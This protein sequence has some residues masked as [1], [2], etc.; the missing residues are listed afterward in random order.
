MNAP[1][2]EQLLDI[3]RDVGRQLLAARLTIATAESCTG[4]L[5]AST[6]T[7]VA[8]SSEYV[9]G[10]VVCYRNSVKEDMLRVHHGTLEL[11]GAVSPETAAEM[12]RGVRRLFGCDVAVAVTG[13]AGPGGGSPDK[14][15]GLVYLHL[16]ALNA[17][18]GR[19]Y[20]WPYD[21]TGNKRATVQAALE[22]I[23]QYLEAECPAA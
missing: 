9:L 1:T 8:G 13:I 4:G 23:Q 15:V 2:F 19:K 3:S 12:A 5:V 14:P 6:L 17:Q 11:H 22:L 21:R 18:W 16:S 20:I 7:D 10:G